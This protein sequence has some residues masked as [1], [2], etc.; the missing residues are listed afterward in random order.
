[1]QKNYN[2]I[3][4]DSER[5]DSLKS[6]RDLKHQNLKA[7]DYMSIIAKVNTS[8]I[9]NKTVERVSNCADFL[10]FLN[11]VEVDSSTGEIMNEDKNIMTHA[12]FC[13]N[14]FCPICSKNKARKDAVRLRAMTSYLEDLNYIFIFLTLTV[15]NCKADELGMLLTTMNE[16]CNR[17]F[18]LKAVSNIS[19]GYVK[20][21]EVTYNS[22]KKAKAYDTYHPHFHILI[23][24]DKDYFINPRKYIKQAKWLDM[25]RQVMKDPSISQVNVKRA[26]DGSILEMSKYI[27]KDSDYLT[28]PTVFNTFYNA[29]KGRQMLTYS[30]YFKDLLKLYEDG[31]LDNHKISSLFIVSSLFYSSWNDTDYDNTSIDFNSLSDEDKQEIERI[32]L[33]KNYVLINDN[34]LYE[35]H[36]V[37]KTTYG[38]D[39]DTE[40]QQNK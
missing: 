19:K 17:L 3:S 12:N 8:L 33:K 5:L 24:V 20:K 35:V 2:T 14:R 22:N 28:S 26:D 4:V 21:V 40:E 10:K 23:C 37:G 1:M 38:K 29:L 15:P 31:K 6:N 27:A 36:Y 25:W 32:L 18:K 34:G 39:T 9:S 13:E 11:C 7:S 16:A 30:G